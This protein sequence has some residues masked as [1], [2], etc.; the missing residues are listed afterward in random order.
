MI[1]PKHFDIWC[2]NGVESKLLVKNLEF[3]SYH[4]EIIPLI[5]DAA[6]VLICFHGRTMID[7]NLRSP[8]NIMKFSGAANSQKRACYE[9]II[10][11][12]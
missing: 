6:I 1:L 5:L 8:Y 4:W 7:L 12:S 2:K 10:P 3:K 9:F 11:R